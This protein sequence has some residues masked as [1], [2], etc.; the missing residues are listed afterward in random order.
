VLTGLAELRAQLPAAT[1]I[2][3]GGS[4]PVLRRR[5]PRDVR[6]L[7]TLHDIAPAVA[8]WRAARSG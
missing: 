3:A 2:W 4:A 1:E 7:E 6:V 8:A 5:P